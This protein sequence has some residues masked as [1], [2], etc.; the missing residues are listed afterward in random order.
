M[1]FSLIITILLTLF[2]FFQGLR[3]GKRCVTADWLSDIMLKQQ[4]LYPFYALHL[5]V[6]FR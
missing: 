2:C 5:P 6:P 4:L 3:E 1:P